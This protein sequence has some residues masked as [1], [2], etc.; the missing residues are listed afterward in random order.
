M[1]ITI[2]FKGMKIKYPSGSGLSGKPCPNCGADSYYLQYGMDEKEEFYYRKY[3]FKCKWG[4]SSKDKE[5][6]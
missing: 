6:K 2:D 1:A 4:E 5:K 3:C